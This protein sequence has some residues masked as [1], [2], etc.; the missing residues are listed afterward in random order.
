MSTPPRHTSTPTLCPAAILTHPILHHG[1][2]LAPTGQF[3]ADGHPH[4]TGVLERGKTRV[5]QRGTRPL[6]EEKD[7]RVMWSCDC[8]VRKDCQGQDSKTVQPAKDEVFNTQVSGRERFHIQT[9]SAVRPSC[10][11]P[12]IHSEPWASL[13]RLR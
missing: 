1:P 11:S 3:S 9:R 6:P 8:Y 7:T 13:H 10:P 12:A 2:V 5:G 4:S